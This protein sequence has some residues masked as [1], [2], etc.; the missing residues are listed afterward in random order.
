MKGEELKRIDKNNKGELPN[1]PKIIITVKNVTNPKGILD[2]TKAIMKVVSQ[3]AYTD[4]WPTD[5]E[6]KEIL[7]IWFVE[8][9]TL[10]TS[11]DRD[12]DENLWHYESW[13][14]NIRQ[15]FWLW[16]SSKAEKDSIQIVLEA[17]SIPYLYDSLLYTFYS[18]G[19]PME[20]I[21][22]KDDVYD[23]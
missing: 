4:K 6:W 5:E 19:V 14:D 22:V 8:S 10:K 1:A 21:D 9:M 17:L 20:N 3:Y 18:Q 11:E 12:R 7:P 2:N 16:Y 15:R 23:S 13:I